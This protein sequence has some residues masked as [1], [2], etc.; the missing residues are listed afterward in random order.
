MQKS[1]LSILVFAL[2]ASSFAWAQSTDLHTETAVWGT[3]APGTKPTLAPDLQR[4][5]S[6]DN[7]KTDFIVQ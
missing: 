5:R 7:T 6:D 1:R 3:R 4:L 2:L